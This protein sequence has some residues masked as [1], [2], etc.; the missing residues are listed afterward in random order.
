MFNA[1]VIALFVFFSFLS[2]RMAGGVQVKIVQEQPDWLR[3]LL[4]VKAK[5]A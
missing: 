3:R 2:P 1:A 5:A 4:R